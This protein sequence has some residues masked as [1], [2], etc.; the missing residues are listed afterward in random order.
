M[1]GMISDARGGRRLAMPILMVVGF[2]VVIVAMVLLVLSL[3]HPV[4]LSQPAETLM[5]IGVG[6]VIVAELLPNI[7]S[8][9]L[10]ASGIEL[11]LEN[12]SE[13]TTDQ[14]L[15]L[16]NRLT[17][18]ELRDSAKGLPANTRSAWKEAPPNLSQ[19]GRYSNDPRKGQF[20]GSATSKGLTL[21]AD[22]L[23]STKNWADIRLRVVPEKPKGKI[24]R[25][26]AVQFFLHNTFKPDLV[27]APFV[28]GQAELTI[29]SWGGFTVGAWIPERDATLE[30]DLAELPNAPAVVRER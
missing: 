2:I 5:L 12:L 8:L 1:T 9:K 21:E 26:S 16:R 3:F 4:Q 13:S 28:D 19:P 18:L 29:T 11:G 7:R 23:K 10:G 22:F 30:L 6:A 15:E 20:G 17:R 25:V 14:I 27:K 24:S